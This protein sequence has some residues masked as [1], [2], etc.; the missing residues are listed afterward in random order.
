MDQNFYPVH[1]IG[2][3]YEQKKMYREAISEFK[4]AS[5]CFDDPEILACLGHAYAICGRTVE[6]KQVLS[7]LNNLSRQIYVDSY[8]IAVIYAGLRKVDQAF[9]WLEKAYRNK[10]TTMLLI[11]VDPRLDLLRSDPRFESLLTKMVLP[12]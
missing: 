12:E 10:D 4:R 9:E 3:P 11:R 1:L 5:Q 7:D 2:L 8:D 6:A